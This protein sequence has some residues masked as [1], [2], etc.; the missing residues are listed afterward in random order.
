MGALPREHGDCDEAAK[1]QKK[2]PRSIPF[3][4][5]QA[6]ANEREGKKHPRGSCHAQKPWTLS[7]VLRSP[8]P[9]TA[10]LKVSNG[11]GIWVMG[12]Q[13]WQAI[14]VVR[15]DSLPVNRS[16][17]CCSLSLKVFPLIISLTTSLACIFPQVG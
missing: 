10:F 12:L 6:D 4:N 2:N 9:L 8:I 17:K 3:G 1:P 5:G 13:L 7:V 14:H 15:H 16:T 11:A